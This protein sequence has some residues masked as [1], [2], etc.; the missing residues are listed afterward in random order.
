M[1]YTPFTAKP[2]RRSSAPDADGP[3]GATI[4]AMSAVARSKAAA[5]TISFAY[6]AILC[7]GVS[8]E[9][10]SKTADLFLLG[11]HLTWV[12]ALSIVVLSHR[13][14]IRH[15]LDGETLFQKWRRWITPS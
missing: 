14:R 7:F 10:Y 12:A 9:R 6:V 11:L 4:V 5:L 8:S 3:R 1:T 13:A 2:A 15:R